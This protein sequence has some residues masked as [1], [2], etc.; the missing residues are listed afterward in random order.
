MNTIGAA[1]GEV[2]D[3]LSAEEECVLATL[4]EIASRQRSS[5]AALEVSAL[6]DALVA[7]GASLS[8]AAGE[9]VAATLRLGGAHVALLHMKGP[10]DG[11]E[12]R[13]LP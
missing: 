2:F 5:G 3:V 6:R 7:G 10:V 1:N 11:V 8:A 4:H 12:V 13:F 9:N